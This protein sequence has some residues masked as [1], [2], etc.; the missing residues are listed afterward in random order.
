MSERIWI[1]TGVSSGFGR[2]LTEQL[3][4]HGDTVIGIVRTP[5]SVADLVGKYPDTFVCESVD[6]RNTSAI[7]AVVPAPS[8][9]SGASTSRSP[10]PVRAS[11]VPPKNC[12]TPRSTRSLQPTSPARS[13]SFARSFRTCAQPDTVG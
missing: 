2:E 11:S 5:D 10:T 8:N 4:T 9:A 3:L 6:V 13:N 1:I 7:R 12:T